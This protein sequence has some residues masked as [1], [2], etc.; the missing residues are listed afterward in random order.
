MRYPRLFTAALL[1]CLLGTPLLAAASADPLR[2]LRPLAET[3]LAEHP[4]VQSAR[5]ELE[6]VEA[7]A[8]AAGRPLYNPE[9]EVDY[10][11]ATDVTKTLGLSQTV[12]WNGK[13]LARRQAGDQRLRAARARLD[14][15]RQQLLGELLGELATFDTAREAA[16]LARH[17][18]ELLSAFLRLAEQRFAAGDVGRA[19][20]DL[21]RLALSEARMRAAARSAAA[22][23]SAARLGALV[24]RPANG[25][26]GLPSLPERL[27]QTDPAQL[28]QRHPRLRQ[29]EAEAAA[30]RA[31]VTSAQ[32]QRRPDP[33]LAVRG[34]READKRLLGLTLSIPLYVR[35]DYSAEVDAAAAAAVRAEQ[36]YR[37]GLRRAR[38]ELEAAA[39]RYRLTRAALRDWQE[40]GRQSLQG[41]TELLQRLWESGEIDTTDHLVQLQQMLD[42]QLASVELRGDVWQAWLAWLQAAGRIEHWL[43]LA[44][45]LT[46]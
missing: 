27:E 42:T 33:T 9:L 23:S 46:P 37:D 10:E 16:R 43:G 44:P 14:A 11:N 3:L 34:G 21:A 13:R 38:A 40:H 41:R 39:E 2:P 19:D 35:N 32:R 24:A 6:Q 28:L 7:E 8:R 18:V 5:A 29:A 1:G 17:R 30:A 15:I 36:A 22:R 45:P 26:P 20:V 31:G 25:W 4:A 12:D